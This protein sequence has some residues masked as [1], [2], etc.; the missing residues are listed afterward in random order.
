[1]FSQRIKTFVNETERG[2]GTELKRTRNE[3]EY[4]RGAKTCVSERRRGWE[5]TGR[6]NILARSRRDLWLRLGDLKDR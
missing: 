5:R 4:V 6:I 2:E 1:M 3:M